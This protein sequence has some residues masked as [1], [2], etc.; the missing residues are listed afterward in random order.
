MHGRGK[1]RRRLEEYHAR[2]KQCGVPILAVN[3]ALYA[4]VTARPLHD[5]LTAIRLGVS[6]DQAGTRLEANAER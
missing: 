6:V 1:D 3:D 4:D 5:L 2:A